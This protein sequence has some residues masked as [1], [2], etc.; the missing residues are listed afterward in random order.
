MKRFEYFDPASEPPPFPGVEVQGQHDTIVEFA[1]RSSLD[2]ANLLEINHD[3][4]PYS[5]CRR[6]LES[7][8]GGGNI[9]RYA[10][11]FGTIRQS[12]TARNGDFVAPI[13]STVFEIRAGYNARFTHGRQAYRLT[14]RN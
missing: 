2:A 1:H 6:R 9:Q 7:D 5:N 3:T 10:G 13:A 14:S 4:F 12:Q 8:A 11:V